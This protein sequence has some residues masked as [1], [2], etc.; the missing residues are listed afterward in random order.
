MN[1]FMEVV[2]RKYAQFTGRARRREYWMFA[3]VGI[4]L[5]LIL[6]VLDYILGLSADAFSGGALT[7]VGNLALLVPHLAVASRRLHDTGRSGWW[8]LIGFIPLIGTVALIV[9]LATDSAE[10]G[11]KWGPNPKAP[12]RRREM[13]ARS[14]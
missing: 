12:A 10:G 1:E 2:T 13:P 6:R 14:W 4:I 3:L 9:F 8:Q 7:A 5:S 11:N